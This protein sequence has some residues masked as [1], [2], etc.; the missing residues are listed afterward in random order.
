MKE[1]ETIYGWITVKEPVIIIVIGHDEE[2]IRGCE[3]QA[4]SQAGRKVIFFKYN[5]VCV[6]CP[7]G[8]SGYTSEHG[9]QISQF[10]NL[11]KNTGNLIQDCVFNDEFTKVV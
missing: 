6:S 4:E 11:M 3:G 5:G 2:K 10:I 7:H 9:N 8:S 1:Y